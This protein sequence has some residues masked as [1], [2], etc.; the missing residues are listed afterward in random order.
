M[1]AFDN[2]IGFEDEI[3]VFRKG[4]KD[5]TVVAD[6]V[7]QVGGGLVREGGGPA[8]DPEV[9]GRRLRWRLPFGRLQRCR[10]SPRGTGRP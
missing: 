10:S 5:G 7:P 3:E 9:F 2:G 4:G 8:L 6:S 1:D